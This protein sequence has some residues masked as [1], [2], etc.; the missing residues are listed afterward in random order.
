MDNYE[1]IAPIGEGTYGMVMKCKH[2]DTGQIVA[3]KKFKE[4]EDDYQIRK[5]AM[6][7]VRMLKVSAYILKK[8]KL[9]YI[10]NSIQQLKN[11]H[12]VN[13]L[14][15]FRRKGKLYLVF[16]HVDHTILEDLDKH[17]RGLPDDRESNIVR[18][19]MWQLLKATDYLHSHNVRKARSPKIGAGLTIRGPTCRRSFIETS[20]P[21]T[22]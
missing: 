6:R 4:S 19:F 20:S 7:E 18:K 14:E 13:L 3:I 16:E 21:K 15:V 22:F 5:T 9:Q 2:R 11:E 12:I 17:P 10:T 1:K 8:R